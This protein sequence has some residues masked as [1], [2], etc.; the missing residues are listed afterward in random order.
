MQTVDPSLSNHD[1]EGAWPYLI[2]DFVEYLHENGFV[3][4]G[5]VNDS[6]SKR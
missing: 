2:D 1:P 5:Q 6:S 4:N 3:Q